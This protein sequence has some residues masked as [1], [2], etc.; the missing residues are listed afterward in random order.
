MG[1]TFIHGQKKIVNTDRTIIMLM[2]EFLQ[3]NKKRTKDKNSDNQTN[4]AQQ[5]VYENTLLTEAATDIVYHYM[6]TVDAVRTLKDGFYS[7]ESS[8]GISSEEELMPKGTKVKPWYLATTR[9]KV[10]DYTLRHGGESG[11]VFELNGRW[12]NQH[13][14][15]LPIDYWAGSHRPSD[16]NTG[17]DARTRE[18]EDRVFSDDYRIPLTGSTVAIHAFIIPFSELPSWSDSKRLGY[19]AAEIRQIIELAQQR[20][21]PVYLYDNKTKWLTQR[22]RYRIDPNSEYGKELLKGTAWEPEEYRRTESDYHVNLKFW[23]ELLEKNPGDALSGPADKLRYYLRHY[24]DSLNQLANNL[25][26]AARDPTNPDY[27]YIIKINRFMSRN[28]IPKVR[29]LYELIR[30]KW[31]NYDPPR[32]Q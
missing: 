32:E 20:N 4:I 3:E 13:Y 17:S 18:A 9:S 31:L 5:Y 28:R 15:T 25:H 23:L 7:L 21:I 16:F 2:R 30:D 11:A 6:S 24:R 19:R 10:G 22:E 14:T 12:L 29:N 1:N 8:T 26:N 27:K